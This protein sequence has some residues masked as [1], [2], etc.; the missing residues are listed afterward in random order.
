MP[1]F[2]ECCVLIPAATLEDFP[3]DL[4]DYDA[5]SMLAAWT[6]LWH[7]RLLASTDQLPNWFRADSPAIPKPGSL[8]LVPAPSQSKLP[9]DFESRVAATADCHLVTGGSREEFWQQIRQLSCG[10]GDSDSVE[11]ARLFEDE[12]EISV[13]DFYAAGYAWLQIQVMTRRLRYTS[14]L[15][16]IH[17]QNRAV[18]AAKAYLDG[19]A[20]ESIAALHDVFDCLAEERD[21][22]FSSSDPHL[23]D[24]TLVSPSTV[25]EM[26]VDIESCGVADVG[27][28]VL[29]TPKNFLID[30][31]V[32]E[33]IS[34]LPEYRIETL[35]RA[36]GEQKIGWA[37]GGP[38]ASTCLDA[39]TLGEAQQAIEQATQICTQ[40]VAASPK[41]FARFSGGWS[42]DMNWALK[43]LGY[44]GVIPIDFAA[45]T[46]SGDEAKVLLEAGS[47]QI[48]ALTAKPIDA[49][50][51]AAFLTLGT[52]LGESIDGGEISTALFAHWPGEGCDSFD[53]VRRAST[54]SLCLGRFWNLEH[55][56]CEG[57]HPYHHGKISAVSKSA[58]NQMDL[59][60]ELG[61]INPISERANHFCEVVEREQLQVVTALAN[62]VAGDNLRC[63]DPLTA[64][65][66]SVI[67][68]STAA[69][70][71]PP[72][73]T[74]LIN[75]DS[76][77]QRQTLGIQHPVAATGK[78]IFAVSPSG[79]STDVTVDIPTC[80]F[81]L[82]DGQGSADRSSPSL[83]QRMR[84]KWTGGRHS[85]ARKERSDGTF[86]LQN[87][88]MEVV[89]SSATGGIAGVYSGSVR[90]N[91]FSMKLV[92][93]QASEVGA[94][95]ETQMVCDSIRVGSSSR[96]IGSI[97]ASGHLR[98]A[99]QT[100]S[101][102]E[103][104]LEFR[105]E[106]G[107]RVLHVSGVL[108]ALEPIVG[109]PWLN[110]FAARGAVAGEAAI[111]RPLIRD[112]VHR[113]SARRLVAPLG[114][115][116][117]EAE[118]QTL[119]GSCGYAFHRHVSDRFLDTLL[120]VQ[121]ES[122]HRFK[123]CYGFDLSSPVATARS[124]IAPAKKVSIR[125]VPSS[126]TVGWIV[127]PAPK[128]VQISKLSVDRM[129][130]GRLTALVRLI[131]TRSQP[132]KAVVRFL[133][134]VESAFEVDLPIEE[135]QSQLRVQSDPPK[136]LETQADRVTVAMPSHGVVDLL[137]IFRESDLVQSNQA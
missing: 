121:N 118:R 17:L 9:A 26:L 117:D 114:I 84:G 3:A 78:H 81:A 21:H 64:F 76:I 109:Q 94:A 92:R 45:G 58:A 96:A 83:V 135:F 10:P 36:I 47:V 7:P 103:F 80:G 6:V 136:R 87:E 105:L 41:V 18:R 65:A 12:R 112:K 5:R 25:D 95:A 67:G 108:K 69:S 71:Q 104:E 99:D 53:D 43:L 73:A 31:D 11:P 23:I 34:K 132:C 38:A 89:I 48:E 55:Y 126:A 79:S 113:G 49:S 97:I 60:I 42:G 72:N 33:S 129:S 122:R 88:F 68:Q 19:N 29:A 116:I 120:V 85:L 123:I 111:F 24:L 20:K 57:A 32:A 98:G 37:G 56:F 128:T 44:S 86:R 82:L 1:D 133:R 124:L 74:L 125:T 50:S 2:E 14:N 27:D 130:D 15:D 61:E 22:Y 54:W 63:N 131:Q 40:A 46:G 115:V 119:V 91:R 77:G 51:D 127:H 35:R 59:A 137:V 62:L 106:R 39:M 16:E 30:Q 90:G 4:S 66:D 52:R 100:T 93:C 134:D 28:R 13:V 8:I 102:A 75:T 110:Y 70:G 101:L 107:S